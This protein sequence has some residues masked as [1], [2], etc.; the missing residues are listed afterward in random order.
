M[1]KLPLPARIYNENNKQCA[2]KYNSKN[3]KVRVD[4]C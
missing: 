2:T 1:D 4:K 3:K